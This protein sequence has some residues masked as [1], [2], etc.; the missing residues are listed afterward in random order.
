M[1]K[2]SFPQTSRAF[3]LIEL[4]FVIAVVGILAAIAI[5]KLSATRTDALYAALNSDIQAVIS[6]VQVA[7]LTQDLSAQNPDGAFIMQTAGL[8]AS[9]W[10]AQGS[11]VR[12]GKNGALDSANNCVMIDISAQSLN[13]QIQP[14][15]SS[16]LC[17]KLAKTYP[18]PLQINLASSIF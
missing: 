17:Q 7:A 15:Q 18:N 12:L 11:G 8:S 9:R 10:I 1:P 16:P 5:P 13:I 14:L 2:T 4:V 6:S 3:S